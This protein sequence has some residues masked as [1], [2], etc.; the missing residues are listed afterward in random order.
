MSE[1]ICIRLKELNEPFKN[2][3]SKIE[4]DLGE[5]ANRLST[6]KA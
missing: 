4:Q 1:N 3:V 6:N 2:I 5:S